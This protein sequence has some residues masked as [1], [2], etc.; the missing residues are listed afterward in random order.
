[1][2][3]LLE[4]SENL[5]IEELIAMARELLESKH[6]RETAT[7]TTHKHSKLRER[8]NDVVIRA[9]EK[10]TQDKATQRALF[11]SLKNSVKSEKLDPSSRKAKLEELELRALEAEKQIDDAFILGINQEQDRIWRETEDDFKQ[12]FNDLAEAQNQEIYQIMHKIKGVDTR[13][14]D[15][16]INDMQQEIDKQK[17]ELGVKHAEKLRELDRRAD[18]LKEIER[19]RLLELDFINNQLRETEEK[20]RKLDE[21]QEQRRMMEERQRKVVEAMKERG[22]SQEKMNE[23]LEQ[24][25]REMNEWEKAMENERVRQQQKLQARLDAKRQKYNERKAQMVAKF[26]EENEKLVEKQ[27]ENEQNKLRII[28]DTGRD[29]KLFTPKIEIDTRLR[30]PDLEQEQA[31]ANIVAPNTLDEVINKVR[32]IEKIAENIDTRQ[33]NLLMKAFSDVSDMMSTMKSKL[34]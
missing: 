4:N 2:E 13:M 14:L 3:Q 25:Q 9:I 21:V 23:I 16:N 30:Y 1:M 12:R 29:V 34:K 18:E 32:R 22:I 19:Q 6:D 28:F 33:F 24:H 31:I 8:Q 7:L 26:K 27:A 5:S 10:K 15:A 17:A 11:E 20:Q